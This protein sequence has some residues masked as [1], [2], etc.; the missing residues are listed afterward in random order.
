MDFIYQ[1]GHQR[2]KHNFYD[3]SHP[4]GSR[5]Y[6]Y[7]AYIFARELVHH[8]VKQRGSAYFRLRQPWHS[9]EPMPRELKAFLRIG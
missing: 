4:E 8:Y 5:T 3:R 6:G 7:A 1:E 2:T 9:P